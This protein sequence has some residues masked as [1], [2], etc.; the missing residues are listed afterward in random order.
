MPLTGPRTRFWYTGK[1]PSDCPGF[2]AKE[3]VLRALPQPN[4]ATC[5]R[6]AVIDYFDNCWTQT[7]VLFACLQGEET[8]YRQPY[9][10]L[11]H[12]MI[13]YYGHPAVLYINKLR[14]AGLLNE[15]IDPLYE[16]LFEVG[17]DEM[18]WDDLSVA[19]DDWPRVAG[20]WA[21][22]QRA[23]RV[24]RQL[25]ETHPC[26]E[27]GTQRSWGEQAWGI[28]MGFE[29]ERIHLETSSVL[30]RELPVACVRH[31]EFWPAY[32]PSVKLPSA[33][34][35]EAGRDYP[36][37]E[38]VD[39]AGGSVVLGKPQEYPSYGWDNEYGSRSI[40]VGPFRA[41][42]FKVTNGEFLQFVRSGGYLERR[43]WTPEGWGWKS[44]RNVK[45]PTFWVPDGP[46]G[47]HRYRLRCLFSVEAMRW[48]WPVDVNCHE[49]AAFAAWATERDGQL[50][51]YRLMT[52]AEHQLIRDPR[53]RSDAHLVEGAQIDPLDPAANPDPAMQFSGADMAAQGYNAALSHSSQWPVTAGRVSE[54]GF[55]DTFGNAWEWGEDHFSGY[56]GFQVHPYYEDFSV[57]C[58]G[59]LHNII[60][61]GSFISTGQLASK[62]ARYQFRPHFFQ[63]ATFRLVQSRAD[64]SQY[65]VAAHS[66]QNPIRP[67]F[68]TSCMDTPAPVVGDAP[69]CSVHRRSQFTPTTEELSASQAEK[70]A[71]ARRIYESDALIAQYL[72]LHF[73]PPSQVFGKMAGQ[74]GIL[75][76]GLDF[77]R[78]CGEAVNSW[79]SQLGIP[80]DRA[81]DLGCAVGG[82]S[83]ALARHF[84]EVVGLDLSS[85]FIAAAERMRSQRAMSYSVPQ[86]GDALQHFSAALDADVDTSRVSFRQG[87]ACDLPA[88][89]GTFDAVLAA[90]LLCRVP[91][92]ARC[93]SEA[94][95]V[96][97]P[98]GL[99]LLTSPFSWMEEY[100]ARQHWLGGRADEQGRVGGCADALK[101]ALAAEFEVVQEDEM[102]LLIREHARK[103]QLIIAHRLALRKRAAAAVKPQAR[104]HCT[105]PRAAAAVRRP[106][107]MAAVHRAAAVRGVGAIRSTMRG[108]C[109]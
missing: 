50:V 25:L 79:V 52:E 54:A 33:T 103:Y 16:Q 55:Y 94:S 74:S 4:T 106:V 18:S 13:F 90:N 95:R 86:E 64:L 29:H 42:K 28:F 9:H 41:S 78:K 105:V 21:Y 3:N 32:H 49:A 1:H 67:F 100:T 76:Q 63:H 53:E 22:R 59:G 47:L 109:C 48:D 69:C 56:P 19:R 5:D 75:E 31:P 24:I 35:P 73:G 46:Q 68:E 82:A 108:V 51:T 34:A 30:I 87:S 23:Y 38:L 104:M 27:S 102:P 98:G 43:Y 20:V 65:D 36:A 71:T 57:P 2:D 93:L 17:V 11:R 70:L 99:L 92:P 84:R 96:L 81:L 7:E 60:I 77:P 89:I 8:F 101:A 88:D 45:W 37:A 72:S 44:F 107:A 40:E 83:F 62:F 39:V 14:V 26:L 58:F 10:Q 61:G 66:P 97:R 12:P 6:Q 15:G 80:A 91:D 85:T